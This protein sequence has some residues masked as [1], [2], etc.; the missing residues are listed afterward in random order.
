LIDRLMR[1]RA[2]IESSTPALCLQLISSMPFL[3][4][5]AAGVPPKVHWFLVALFPVQD[6]LLCA[7]H[8]F[9]DAK[10]WARA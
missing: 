5:R 8:L 2:R 7:K 10:E 1:V 3:P 9:V 4:M 6:L